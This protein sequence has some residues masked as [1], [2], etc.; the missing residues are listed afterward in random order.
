MQYIRRTRLSF[1]SLVL[2]ASVSAAS[3]P[4]L[5]T[6][7]ALPGADEGLTLVI[8]PSD[9]A[10]AGD[11]MD[12]DGD[13]LRFRIEA[14][15]SGTLLV[16]T[17][18]TGAGVALVLPRVLAADEQLLWTPGATGPVAAFSVR[19]WDGA[20]A[21]ATAVPVVVQVNAAPVLSTLAVITGAA[22]AALGDEDTQLTIPGSALLAAA[23][24]TDETAVTR[25]VVAALPSG[26]SLLMQPSDDSTAAVPVTA[27]AILD[28]ATHKLLWTPA[29]DANGD[30]IVCTLRA[31]DGRLTSTVALGLVGR[32]AAVQDT[33]NGRIVTF[34][35]IPVVRGVP[36]E[37]TYEQFRAYSDFTDPDGDARVWIYVAPTTAVGWK[38]E[39]IQADGTP[40][41][42]RW[43]APG[44]LEDILCYSS[45]RIRITISSAFPSMAPNFLSAAFVASYPGSTNSAQLN[46]S[47]SESDGSE[48]ASSDGGG[49]GVCGAGA[50]GVLLMATL[51]LGL[52]TAMVRK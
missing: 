38:I 20:L 46:I 14:V 22:G 29:Q 52:S 27:G 28:T 34:S 41:E 43:S 32:V 7:A 8:T 16:R 47:V 17:G 39:L 48:G 36:L 50:V 45:Q 13:V 3:A 19:A 31:W 51:L 15:T 23:T 30:L 24:A 18:S 10:T 21:S 26:G 35:P 25:F 2:A 40:D 37:L 12:T 1:L 33:L 42:T 5:T 11:E 49:S 4:E 44:H 6:M 9:L